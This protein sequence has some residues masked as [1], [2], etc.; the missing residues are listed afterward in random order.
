MPIFYNYGEEQWFLA[1]CIFKKRQSKEL[2]ERILEKINTHKINQFCLENNVDTTLD[3]YITQCMKERGGWQ[4]VVFSE[5][6]YLKKE[7]KIMT[8]APNIKRYLVFPRKESIYN[9]HELVEFM[10]Q[11]T[12]YSFEYPNKYDDAADS[13]SMFLNKFVSIEGTD[14]PGGEIKPIDIKKFGGRI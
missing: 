3:S 12:S 5:Y 13:V 8:A 9:N 1:D 11:L 4:C 10:E 14:S 2:I 6:S 7:V